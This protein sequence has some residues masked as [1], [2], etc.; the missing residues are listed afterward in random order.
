MANQAQRMIQA[1]GL[2]PRPDYSAASDRP[3]LRH[4]GDLDALREAALDPNTGGPGTAA[5]DAWVGVLQRGEDEGLPDVQ[6]FNG[7]IPASVQEQ[8][9]AALEAAQNQQHYWVDAH[10]LLR[11]MTIGGVRISELPVETARQQIALHMAEAAPHE[12]D[13]LARIAAAM[14]ESGTSSIGIQWEAPEP[15]MQY[16]ARSAATTDPYVDWMQARQQVRQGMDALAIQRG[17]ADAALFSGISP[18]G[19]SYSVADDAAY[20]Q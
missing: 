19:L 2:H 8:E 5:Y 10:P 18:D 3:R 6:A 14:D 9:A 12:R 1:L 7:A 20:Q 15:L 13:A 11:E 16:E 4:T 17:D